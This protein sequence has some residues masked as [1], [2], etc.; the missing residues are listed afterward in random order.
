MN[1]ACVCSCVHM[2]VRLCSFP[3][4]WYV[5]HG[6]S[7]W[8]RF[9]DFSTLFFGTVSQQTSSVIVQLI[10]W[11]G[12][13]RMCPSPL[14]SWYGLSYPDLCDCWGIELKILLCLSLLIYPLS[15][16]S[17]SIL[18]TLCVNHPLRKRK[19]KSIRNL[20]HIVLDL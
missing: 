7:L 18:W 5:G 10:V 1:H 4:L 8:C 17:C 16:L 11:S 9:C 6:M 12:A 15:Y 19:T 2:C 14:S 3:Y 20:R 13:P